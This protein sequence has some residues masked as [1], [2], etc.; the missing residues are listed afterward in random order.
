[1]KKI[2]KMKN[3]AQKQRL[4]ES[5][6]PMFWSYPFRDLNKDEDASLI[7]KQILSYGDLFQWKWMMRQYGTRKIKGI[8]SRTPKT[9]V[10]PSLVELSKTVFNVTSMPHARRVPHGRS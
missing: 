1:M 7:I 2:K 10:R 5:F 6:R 3:T 8:L 4:P 9:A